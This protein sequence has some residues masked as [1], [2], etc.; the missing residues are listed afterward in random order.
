[1]IQGMKHVKCKVPECDLDFYHVTI[2][3]YYN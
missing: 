2:K 1:M 3:R